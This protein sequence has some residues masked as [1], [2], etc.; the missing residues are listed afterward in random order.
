MTEQVLAG[1]LKSARASLGLTIGEAAKRLGY[2]NYHTLSNIESGQRAVKASELNAF[3]RIYSVS[4][5]ELLGVQPPSVPVRMLWRKRDSKR[6]K[7]AEARIRSLCESYAHLES[8]VGISPASFPFPTTI[9]SRADIRTAADV[10]RIAREACRTL[11]LG[12]RPACGL[13][14][15]LEEDY[16]VKLLYLPLTDAGSAASMR[17]PEWGAVIAVNSDDAP[18]RRAYDIAHEL[19]H[20]LSWDACPP[21]ALDDEAVFA[22]V[23]K[24]A[25]RFAST[26]LLPA[27]EIVEELRARVEKNSTISLSDLV[28]IA[29][30]FG[31]SS[32][33]LLY[34]LAKMELLPW[35]RAS[36]LA[37]GRELTRLDKDKR[38]SDRGERPVSE[39]FV[40]LA[41][42]CL[43][44][45]ILSRGKFAELLE[46]DRIDIDDF[47]AERGL[48]EHE[49]AR[50]KIMAP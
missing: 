14:K 6:A 35:E 15:V 9:R 29:R 30:E 7:E 18:W 8:A 47:I 37:N 50:I 24:K 16:S 3:A 44:K 38:R 2:Q 11:N 43:R 20:L 45:G 22:D 12:K 46:I 27:G 25:E 5:S 41:V 34:R 23:E 26:L 32:Q 17:H 31:V 21:D 10:D 36:E 1:R 33:A 28:D 48:M 4:I 40:A 13:G 19:F 49:G 42:R 39:R